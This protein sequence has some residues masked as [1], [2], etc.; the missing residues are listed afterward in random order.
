MDC[1]D[2]VNIMPGK[3]IFNKNNVPLI[4]SGCLE[5]IPEVIESI[6]GNSVLDL[7]CGYGRIGYLVFSNWWSTASGAK[8]A[9]TDIP[10]AERIK[11]GFMVGAD[12]LMHNLKVAKW[13][14]VYDEHVQANACD[15][16]F[17]S[18]SF[19]TIVCVEAI[20]HIAP[21]K[22]PSFFQELDRVAR[23]R[24][25]IT[26]PRNPSAEIPEYPEGWKQLEDDSKKELEAMLHRSVVSI[27]EF[28]KHGY[29]I[30]GTGFD[31]RFKSRILHRFFLLLRHIYNRFFAEF[32]IATKTLKE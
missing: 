31:V 9:P 17:K 29:K 12:L 7:G 20:E 4:A 32:I 30:S 11:R 1:A 19:D 25:I 2:G 13:H 28:K 6:K 10:K 27:K 5:V 16:P 18:K 14:R 15:L 23:K 8:I 26:T 22:I 24:I 3:E 21:E